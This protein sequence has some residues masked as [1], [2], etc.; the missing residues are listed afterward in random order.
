MNP[1]C[2]RAVCVVL[3]CLSALSALHAA[4]RPR[5]G[6]VLSGGGARGAAHVGVIRVL[7]RLRVPVDVVAGSSMGAIVGGLYASGKSAAELTAIVDEIDFD[8]SFIDDPERSRLSFRRKQDDRDFLIDFGFGI[9]AAGVELPRGLVQGQKLNML[10]KS[11]TLAVAGIEDFDELPIP[12]RAVATDIETGSAVVLGAGNLAHAMR[13]SMAVPGIFAPIEYGDRLLVDGGVSNNLPID[14]ARQMGA[15][16]LI[17]VDLQFPLV[18]RDEL[19]SALDVTNQLLTILVVRESRE[20]L[21]TLGESDIVIVPELGTMRSGD[22]ELARSALAI[23]EA[24]ALE[25]QERLS[26]LSLDAEAYARYTAARRAP[27]GPQRIDFVRVE[28]GNALTRPVLEARLALTPGALDVGELEARIAELYGLDAFELVDFD[29][30]RDGS[31]TGLLVT[32][33]D[34]SWGPD[35][36]NFGARLI[37]DL[38]GSSRYT[39]GA[40]YTRTAVNE[41]GAEWRTDLQIGTNPRIAT[42]FYQPLDASWRYF[43]APQASLERFETAVFDNETRIAEFFVSSAR[44]RLDVGRTFGNWGELRLGLERTSGRISPRTGTTEP[45]PSRFQA[46]AISASFGV[47]TID[48]VNFPRSGWQASVNWQAFRNGLGSPRASDRVEAT[49]VYAHTAGPGTWLFAQRAGTNIRGEGRLQDQFGL[50]G[51]FNLSGLR[52]SQLRG[53]HYAIVDFLYYREL[54]PA[55]AVP[56]YAGASLE[57]GNVWDTSEEVSATDAIFAGSLFIGLDTFIGPIY[58]AYGLAEGGRSAAYFLLGRRF[59]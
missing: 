31:A 3:L 53:Q 46:G 28:G 51:L 6:L 26:A 54:D 57:F 38:E 19:R 34:K 49:S 1:N 35:Y 21:A 37:D 23:G 14:V 45:D 9:G 33:T 5:V 22:F 43:I 59:E 29:F 24:S 25:Q 27:T 30:V 4:E 10:L 52:N 8:D 36:V 12:F 50:G 13:A 55:F 39:L 17:V 58:L 40:R 48:D 11:Q 20:Q 16:V 2:I 44:A 47:D 32:A 42:E 7:E 56:F 15:D 41:L 18:P